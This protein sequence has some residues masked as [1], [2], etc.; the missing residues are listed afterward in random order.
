MEG[1]TE[2]RRWEV[3]KCTG[4]EERSLGTYNLEEGDCWILFCTDYGLKKLINL[5]DASFYEAFNLS[6]LARN[7]LAKVAHD[8]FL[9]RKFRE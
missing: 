7:S 2:E 5:V 6:R 8:Y 9:H 1:E 3:R 4:V